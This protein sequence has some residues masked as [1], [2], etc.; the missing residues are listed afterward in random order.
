MPLEGFQSIESVGVLSSVTKENLKNHFYP[1][2]TY[3][4]PSLKVLFYIESF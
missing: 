1:N 4:W 2:E 3:E